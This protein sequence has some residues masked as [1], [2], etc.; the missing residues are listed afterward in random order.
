MS[1]VKIKPENTNWKQI[2][3]HPPVKNGVVEDHDPH[4]TNATARP[5]F[6]RFCPISV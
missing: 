2:G 1:E 6:H 5:Y 4:L 3:C